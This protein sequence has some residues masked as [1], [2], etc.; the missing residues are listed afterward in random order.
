MRSNRPACPLDQ[1]LRAGAVQVAQP[2][3]RIDECRVA[4]VAKKI[5]RFRTSANSCADDDSGSSF[6]VAIDIGYQKHR[7]ACSDCPRRSINC[8]TVRRRSSLLLKRLIASMRSPPRMTLI[9]SA[10][11]EM[12]V[13]E[14][15]GRHVQ[16]AGQPRGFQHCTLAGT[17][18]HFD[19]QILVKHQLIV[20]A[21][22]LEKIERFSVTTHQ[23]VLPVVDEIAGVRIGERIRTPAKRGFSLEHRDPHAALCERDRRAQ[24]RKAGADNDRIFWS[25]LP[26]IRAARRSGPLPTRGRPGR[27]CAARTGCGG[28]RARDSS[29]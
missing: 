13:A 24:S 22:S 2:D 8:A 25:R 20:G 16:R 18:E 19:F 26:F 12:P 6:S 4:R 9:R 29:T 15:R 3:A 21:D 11:A 1:P 10:I 27:A 28:G 5:A 14:Q 7:R 23:D 17:C